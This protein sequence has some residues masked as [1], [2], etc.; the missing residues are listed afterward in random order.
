MTEGSGL[1]GVS[2]ID[3]FEKTG[4][5]TNKKSGKCQ[6]LAEM[7]PE[8]CSGGIETLGWIGIVVR[9]QWKASRIPKRPSKY[10]KVQ[11]A[12]KNPKIQD[13]CIFP[14]G[15]YRALWGPS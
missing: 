10:Q 15:P 5:R 4:N 7:D 8:K 9:I 2:G 11:K 14:I 13:F 12:S 3:F 6:Q 1:I